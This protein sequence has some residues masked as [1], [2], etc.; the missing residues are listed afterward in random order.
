MIHQINLEEINSNLLYIE[1]VSN[2]VNLTD[3]LSDTF[4]Y[5]LKIAKD[6]LNS[7]FPK[8]YKR[9]LIN[10]LGTVIKYIAGNPDQD[11]LDILQHNLGKIQSTINQFKNNHDKQIKINDSVQ[12]TINK[13]SVTIGKLVKRFKTNNEIFRK[14]VE[15]INLILNVDIIIK[16]LEDIEEQ[17][18]FSKSNILNKNILSSKDKNY[19]VEFLKNQGIKLHFED[20]IFEFVKCVAVIKD[21]HVFFII[22]IP[23]VENQDYD[24]IQLETT[25]INGSR[26]NMET[27]YVAKFKRSIYKQ[28]GQC[29]L[30][31][32]THKLNDG[33]IFSILTNQP[34]KCDMFKDSNRI[35]V[36]EITPGTVLLDSTSRVHVS[37]S[38]GDDRIIA[39]PMIIETENCTVTIL[40]RTFTQN[41]QTL[42][43]PEFSTPIFGKQI[44]PRNQLPD[45]EEIHQVN[46]EN[47]EEITRI[48]LQLFK[49]Q[50]IGGLTIAS[51]TIFLLI[52]VYLHRYKNHWQG[53]ASNTKPEDAKIKVPTR[54]MTTSEETPVPSK[55]SII[56]EL[57]TLGNHKKSSEDI[58][59]TVHSCQHQVSSLF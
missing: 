55:F 56:P 32:N 41:L 25:N 27:Q 9:G 8:R 53:K 11:D 45:I 24:L 28:T 4:L 37:D 16:T 14:E 30:C 10:G 15:E 6:K 54:D 29:V 52:V 5:K 7:L 59:K 38:C 44:E 33:C 49:S 48:R 23:I 51:I 2:V 42:S 17:F 31:D 21:D 58:H 47:L 1:N 35:V 18:I 26:I 3:H 40:N 19:I 50:T 12:K 39:A 46:M 57:Q 20:E 34:A 13:V 22:K 43:S 36:K